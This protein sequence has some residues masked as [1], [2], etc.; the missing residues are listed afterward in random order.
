MELGIQQKEALD[1]IIDFFY[2]NRLRA[3]SLEGYAGTG[4]SFLIKY[5]IEYLETKYKNYV[6]VAPTHKAKVVLERFTE[7]EGMTLHKLLSLSPNIEILDLDFKY[8][9]FLVKNPKNQ[10][11]PTNGI[12]ICDEASMINDDLYDLLLSK[13]KQFNTKIL[14][15]SDKAQLKPVNGKA[16]SK[17][18][19]LKHKY[20][21][22][23][24]YRQDGESGLNEV[25][26]ILRTNAIFR[27]NTIEKEVGSVICYDNVKDWFLP[28]IKSFKTAM[29]N[30]DI[31]EAKIL[32]YT[33][34]RTAAFNN[35]V[36]E[37][38]FKSDQQYNKLE[39][40]TCYDNLT[41][42]AEEFWNSMDYIIMDEAIPTR[43]N[44]PGFVNLPGF[45]LTLYDSSYKKQKNILILDKEIS[46]D[47]LDSLAMYI[48]QL[49]EEA[50]T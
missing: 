33:N 27:F 31:L 29:Q 47:Y 37:V 13:A 5:I 25:L 20:S 19:A 11:F 28:S 48:E 14:F 43:I 35:K 12:V 10:M 26:P 7:R 24:I 15:V 9:E 4:K 49:R 17:V 44:I 6:L 23:K 3:F 2:D 46:V 34:N 1:L 42:D 8:L 18:Y 40:L 32:A 38:L 22:S 50:I 30:Q 45:K 39:L 16:Y 36:K 21:L 41:F